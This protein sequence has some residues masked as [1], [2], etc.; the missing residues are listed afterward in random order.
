MERKVIKS[1]ARVIQVLE[2]FDQVKRPQS[3]AE[4]ADHHS[5]PHS[6]TSALM[7][8]LVMLGYVH[9]DANKR[10]YLPSM[11]VALLGDWIQGNLLKDGQLMRL[12][13][14]L[15][16][17]SS[18]SIVLAS[19]NGLHSQYLRVVQGTTALRMHLHIGM[20]RPLFGSGTGSML[21]SQMDD[22]TIRKLARK[23]NA[24]A[25]PEKQVDVPKVLQDIAAD[26]ARGYAMSLNQV[27]P[28]SG[29]IAML[30][31][32]APTEKPLVL[33]ISG[34]TVRLVENEHRYVEAMRNGMKRFVVE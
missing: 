30:L 1:A 33:G 2:F 22:N 28:H 13:Q 25:D 20:L 24:V 29:L 14:H 32:T 12:M 15:N 10:T 27:T 26:R 18:E 19:Q 17:E 31:P 11:R 6:S 3:V 34:L 7:S 9:Y 16:D 23:F 21:L 5:W 8:S 4:I